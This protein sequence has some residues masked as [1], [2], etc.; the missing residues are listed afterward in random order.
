MVLFTA[1]KPFIA[2]A[3]FS[4]A[5]IK[6]V[7]IEKLTRFIDW[8]AETHMADT[9][10]PFILG[11]IGDHTFDTILNEVFSVLKIKNKKVE[12]RYLTNFKNIENCNLLFIAKSE[13][14]SLPEILN[15][16]VGHPILTISDTQGFAEKGVLIN[17]YIAENKMRFEINQAAVKKSQLMF[18]SMLLNNARIVNRVE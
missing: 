17:F 6:A 15:Y 1:F 10:Q 16:T 8:P 7:Y 14:Q 11:V 4:E 5:E 12:I 3:Q 18:D 2:S 9:I 13:K